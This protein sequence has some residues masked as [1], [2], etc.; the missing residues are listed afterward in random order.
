MTSRV[1]ATVPPAGL[2]RLLPALFPSGSVTGAPK[3]RSMQIIDTLERDPRGVYTGA[4]GYAAPDG[5][6]HFNVAIRTVTLDGDGRAEFGVGS[7]I[8][9]DSD[10]DEEYEECLV[11][12]SML[13][14]ADPP[15]SLL[16]TFLWEPGSGARRARRHLA[17][18]R[19]S[20]EYFGRPF[21][22]AAA[23]GAIAAAVRDASGASR[24]RLL[25]HADGGFECA[26]TPYVAKPGPWRVALA[27]ERVDR[28]D[29]RLFHKTTDRRRYD[30]ARAARPDVDTLLLLNADDEV[31]E[32]LEANLV[33]EEGGRRLTPALDCGLLPGV[34]RAELLDAGEIAEARI[35]RAR[36]LAAPRAWL[37]NSLRGWI[38][39]TIVP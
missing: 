24:V 14:A 11:K 5:R 19:D 13:A 16:E 17:R 6:S 28:R 2:S 29:A 26:S 36:L 38:P 1:T 8:V 18:M 15:F 12:A 20:A 23:E 37:I 31:T 3:H 39:V 10:P 32:A 4:V 25:L 27:G 33:I 21:D 30:R 35:T 22:R 7:G 9:W 34:L